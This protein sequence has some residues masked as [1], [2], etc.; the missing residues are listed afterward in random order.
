MWMKFLYWIEKEK[1]VKWKFILFPI[2]NEKN[3]S[4]I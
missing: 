1:K 4:K 3:F 2:W